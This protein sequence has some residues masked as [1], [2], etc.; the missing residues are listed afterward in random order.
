MYLCSPSQFSDG[1]CPGL[2]QEAPSSVT[3]LAVNMANAA[4]AVG[5]VVGPAIGGQ[6]LMMFRFQTVWAVGAPF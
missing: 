3:S 5:S 6:L 1:V 2:V 4:Y